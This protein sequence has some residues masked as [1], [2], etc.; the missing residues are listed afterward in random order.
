MTDQ[1]PLPPGYL[2]LARDM[3]CHFPV[4]EQVL[5]VQ[6]LGAGLINSTFAVAAHSGHFV[7][8][9]INSAVFADPPLIMDNIARLQSAA[10]GAGPTAPRL[11][12]LFQAESAALYTRDQDGGYWRLLE[13]VEDA[14]TLPAV[15]DST[16]AAAIGRLLGQFH[17]FGASLPMADFHVTLPGS[18]DTPRFRAALDAAL[19]EVARQTSDGHDASASGDAEVSALI[20]QVRARDHVLGCLRDAL[21][22]GSIRKTLIHGDPKR[23]NV[24]FDRQ[25]REA[26][27]LIDL[28]T[29]QPGLILHDIGDC[30]RSCCNRAG[31][32]GAPEQVHFDAGL[33][34]AL[35]GG[36]A[37]AAPG[38]LGAAELELL[39]D[40]MR[41]IPLELGMRF[42]I[43]HLRGD[44]YFRVRYRGENLRKAKAQLA[45]VADIERQERHLRQLARSLG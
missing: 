28:D 2:A 43:D 25:G 8:Q 1:L 35:L 39:F 6:P 26:L 40:A 17:G 32:R 14:I 7:L 27:C 34:E 41:L 19:S 11:P 37:Q 30:L 18:H 4:C 24:L 21:A 38:L 36:Y 31:E 5:E 44:R 22:G 33:A 29:V 15:T 23:D 16:Q 9:R 20:K 13:R 12:R 10:A 42:L 3:A 45:L